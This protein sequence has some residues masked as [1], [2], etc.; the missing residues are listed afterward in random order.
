[1]SEQELRESRAASLIGRALAINAWRKKRAHVV[2]L[3]S[4][5]EN[6]EQQLDHLQLQIVVLRKLLD[7]ENARVSGLAGELHKTK[8]QIDDASKDRDQ[9]KIV[10]FHLFSSSVY[11]LSIGE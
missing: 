2:E 10:S 5:V 6:L 1:M 7:K 9:L 4:T 3:K 11:E 8:A